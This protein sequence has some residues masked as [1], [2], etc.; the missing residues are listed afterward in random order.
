MKTGIQPDVHV[1]WKIPGK[2]SG[3]G[4]LNI[5]DG[6]RLTHMTLPQK[7]KHNIHGTR[8]KTKKKQKKKQK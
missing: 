3:G 2:H 8:E 5:N 4:I 1:A 6:M 7:R